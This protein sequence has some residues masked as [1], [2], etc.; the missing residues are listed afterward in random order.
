M[1]T[2]CAYRH[3]KIGS[4]DCLVPLDQDGKEQIAAMALGR[5]VMVHVHT[6]R[7]PRHHRLMFSLWNLLH[8]GGVFDGD[9]DAFIEWAKYRTGHVR[10]SIDPFGRVNYIPKSMAFESMP[11][12]AFK[13]F[14]DRVTWQVFTH[15]LGGSEGDNII[16]VTYGREH[17]DH[18][19]LRDA[20]IEAVDGTKNLPERRG[21]S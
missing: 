4:T 21:G 3:V 12:D 10:T 6:A 7:N 1:P 16:S 19:S 5:D 2:K 18:I 11:Q 9:Q 8:E 14:F 15:L 17:A 20:V 13:R